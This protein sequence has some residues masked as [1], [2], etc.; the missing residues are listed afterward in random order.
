MYK[1]ICKANR[2]KLL[3]HPSKLLTW[4]FIIVVLLVAQTL[5]A[6]NSDAM[7]TNTTTLTLEPTNLPTPTP[8]PANAPISTD[9]V[10]ANPTITL[11]VDPVVLAVG[12]TLTV[13]PHPSSYAQVVNVFVLVDSSQIAILKWWT[14]ETETYADNPAFQLLPAAESNYTFTLQALKAGTFDISLS[15]LGDAS[16]CWV[17]NDKTC[18]CGTTHKTAKSISTSVTVLPSDNA[19]TTDP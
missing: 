19:P 9:C 18:Q 3:Y 11:N 12:D 5:T 6:C 2:K 8:E 10:S 15:V 17:D 14:G 13:V 16:F 7:P 1:L 4:A